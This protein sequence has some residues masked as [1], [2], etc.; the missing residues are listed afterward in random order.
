MVTR[1]ADAEA[2]ALHTQT[3]TT[4]AYT[5]ALVI[6]EAG[7][8]LSHRRLQERISSSLPQLA[9]F[10]SRLVGKPFGMGQ[11]V[12]A[13]IDGY[14]PRPHIHSATVRAPG[15][16]RQ[17]AELVTE[18]S[19]ASRV[20]HRSLWEAWT[21]DGLAGG[22]WAL[23]VRTSPALGDGNISTAAWWERLLSSD[24]DDQE[25]PQPAEPGLGPAPSL[26][27]LITDTVSEI[28]E[29][30]LIGAWMGVDGF[31]AALQRLRNKLRGAGEP[32]AIT[33][34]APSMSGPVPRNVFNAPL[35]GRRAMAFASIPLADMNTVTNAFGGS[36]AN[37]FLAACTLSLRAWLRQYDVV[38]DNPLLMDIPLSRPTGDAAKAGGALASGQVRVPVQLD[39]PVQIL[40]NLYTATERLNATH[41]RQAEAFHPSIDISSV[42]SVL[43]PSV[44]H[45]GMHLYTALGLTRLR[46]PSC[47][48]TV[49]FVSGLPAPTYC[50]G[51][52]VVA[53]HTV[54]PLVEGCGLNITATSHADV[55]DFSVA[56]CPDNVPEVDEIATGI[57]ESLDVLLEAAA[58]S[59]R[60]HG[61][62]VVSEMTSRATRHP[63][64]D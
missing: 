55:M 51:T 15:T 44:V 1:L 12:W 26:G 35:T 59:P 25:C 37:V 52:K 2:M 18:L 8:Q 38:P 19:A 47:H 31:G 24:Q 60:G 36:I 53:M 40:T 14:D 62:S 13:E 20:G 17:L 7:D 22:R 58:R 54:A 39:D 34:V 64:H 6:L 29:N 9:R 57:A 27:E 21:I 63:R 10:R 5:V 30:Q 49:A 61:Q 48:G 28:A 46:P 4:P 33:P 3:P 23:A 16:R 42:A 41:S 32:P 43:A 11:P 56:A 45:A 50:A